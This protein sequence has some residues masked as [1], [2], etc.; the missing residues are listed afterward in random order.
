VT[1]PRERAIALNEARLRAGYEPVDLDVA[2]DFF[3]PL[4]TGGYVRLGYRLAWLR[5][6]TRSVGRRVKWLVVGR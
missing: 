4:G 3:T 2:T 1:T 5:R 6:R